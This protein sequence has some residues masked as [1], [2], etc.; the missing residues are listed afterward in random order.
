[1]AIDSIGTRE[2]PQR[3]SPYIGGAVIERLTPA[4][5]TMTTAHIYLTAA[6]LLKKLIPLNSTGA[7]N[8]VLPTADV[9]VAGKPGIGVG[10]MLEFSVINYGN[11][12]TTLAVNTGITNKVIDSEDAILTIA[13]HI[14]TR[15]ALVCTGRAKDSDPSASNTFDLYL[16]ATSTCTS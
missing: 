1:M 3:H 12:T 4:T 6:Q 16:L 10:D 15:W 2:T 8:L 9:L 11:D 5:L 7:G 14:G 13:T